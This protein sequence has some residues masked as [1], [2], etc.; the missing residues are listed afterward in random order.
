M[1]LFR[2]TSQRMITPPRSSCED[3]ASP[4]M[5][6]FLSHPPVVSY[7][8][9][10]G[11]LGSLRSDSV[12]RVLTFDPRILRATSRALIPYQRFH[13]RIHDRTV[14]KEVGQP[15]HDLRNLSDILQCLADATTGTHT[16]SLPFMMHLV[17][18]C[19]SSTTL[20]NLATA[21]QHWEYLVCQWCCKIS[22]SGVCQGDVD[23][24]YA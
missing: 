15:I 12:G 13:P 23:P 7:T 18:A 17:T 11:V 5:V 24:Y 19:I 21:Y 3:L 8:S 1:A 22:R 16:C 2:S 6:I 10:S 20:N 9:T 14:F 4:A